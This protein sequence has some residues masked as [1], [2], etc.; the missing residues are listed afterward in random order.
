MIIA[1][2]AVRARRGPVAGE[3][4]LGG[5]WREGSRIMLI[6]Y[7]RDKLTRYHV[8]VNAALVVV[9]AAAG[10]K[11]IHT[12]AYTDTDTHTH[13]RVCNKENII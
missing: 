8:M 3:P 7:V 4:V 13:T 11:A 12:Y 1:V 9:A 6:N 5:E 2:G 10:A